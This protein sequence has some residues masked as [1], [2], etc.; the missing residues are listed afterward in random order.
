MTDKRTV[1]ELSIEELE[2]ILAIKKREA[3]QQRLT[4]MK[5]SGRV[6]EAAPRAAAAPRAP[7][8]DEVLYPEYNVP[9]TAG[10]APVFEDAAPA[11]ARPRK[12]KDTTLW[13]RFV[14]RSLLLVEVV[15]VIGLIGI[16]AVLLNGIS[17]L[18]EETAQAQRDA[19]QAIRASMPTM[20]P[21]P[22]L[23]LANIVLPG[24]HTSPLEAGG[25]QFNFEE[26]PA[27]LRELLRDQIFLPPQI[28]RPPVLPETPVRVIIP[29]LNIDEPIVQGVDWEAL[30][31]GVGQVLNGATP[32]DA[33]ANIVLAAHND[34]YGQL[35]R[36][37]DQLKPG[38][39]FQIQTQTRFYDYVVTSTDIVNPNDVYVMEPRG[40]PAVTLISCYPY[41][42]N[43]KRYIVFAQQVPS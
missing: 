14:D 9:A 43:N 30:K 28:S 35:F 10:S 19:Q 34:I 38:M 33:N 6:I 27:N 16:G 4:R 8:L 11:P 20:V 12:P 41:Q 5:S 39:V 18:Q 32:T 1:D 2:R 22:T 13:Q 37:L 25:G 42:V 15:A 29:D 36:Y 23:Q 24:G 17:L 26:I 31:L 7:S 21:T 3:R 40:Y